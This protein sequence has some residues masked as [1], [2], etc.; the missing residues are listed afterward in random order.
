MGPW[1][2]GQRASA[3]LALEEIENRFWS[4]SKDSQ[5]SAFWGR[6][7]DDKQQQQLEILIIDSISKTANR[8]SSIPLHGIR[9][10]TMF[11]PIISSVFVS[12]RLQRC[13]NNQALWNGLAACA[14]AQRNHCVQCTI[15]GRN[16]RRCNDRAPVFITFT[17][18]TLQECIG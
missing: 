18:K 2:T 7:H 16:D 17:I 13:D 15:I 6:Q 4:K 10:P 8:L 14:P 5:R 11:S 3:G 9:Q 1:T 12:Q